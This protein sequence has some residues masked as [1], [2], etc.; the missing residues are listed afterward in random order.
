MVAHVFNNI[1]QEVETGGSLDSW[2]YTEKSCLDIQ[3]PLHM[4]KIKKSNFLFFFPLLGLG[5]SM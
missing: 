5:F 1:I 4:Q 3:P 2:G